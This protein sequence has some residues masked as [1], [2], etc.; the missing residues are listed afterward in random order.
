MNYRKSLRIGLITLAAIVVLLIGAAEYFLGYALKPEKHTPPPSAWI[1]SVQSRGLLRDT[2]ILNDEGLRLH[3]WYYRHTSAG[4]SI[5]TQGVAILVHGYGTHA[6]WMGNIASIYDR[7]LH[8]DILLPDM[9]SFGQSEGTT[10]SMGWKERRDLIS[11]C[12]VAQT[13]FGRHADTMVLHGV[14]MGAATVMCASGEP[15]LPPYVSCVVEDCGYTSVWDEFRHQLKEQFCLPAFPL[16]HVTNLL[17]GL[18]YGWTFSSAS[19]KEQVGKC[20]LPMLF[21]HGEKDDFVRTE[22]VHELYAAKSGEK[23]LWIA[24]GSAHA[25]SY[26]D[27]QQEYTQR[28]VAFVKRWSTHK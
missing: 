9:R 13:L 24:P 23:E 5:D 7:E 15:D 8:Y 4:D 18:H 12:H 16:M 6:F 1:D 10:T 25:Q 11:W 27:H 28:V 2:F 26:S 3:A 20:H 21:I 14:S 19:P 17:C 22:M